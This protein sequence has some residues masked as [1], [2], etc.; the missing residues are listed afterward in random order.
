MLNGVTGVNPSRVITLETVDIHKTS[1][2]QCL[3]TGNGNA[4]HVT[5]DKIGSI[6]VQ[7]RYSF[8]ERAVTQIVVNGSRQVTPVVSRRDIDDNQVRIIIDKLLGCSGGNIDIATSSR[9][10]GRRAADENCGNNK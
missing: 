9:L 10:L 2:Y 8:V 7:H 6:L 3:G 1:V 4:I 5:I